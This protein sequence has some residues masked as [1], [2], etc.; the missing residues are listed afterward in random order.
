M[1]QRDRFARTVTSLL[2]AQLDD[3]RW[4]AASALL[5]DACDIWGNHL[6]V[7]HPVSGGDPEMVFGRLYKRGEPDEELERRYTDDYLAIDERMPRFFA[8]SDGALNHVKVMF[9][10]EELATSPTYNEFLVPSGGENAVT[11]RMAGPGGLHI[12]MSLVRGG[13][14]PSSWT[15]DQVQMIQRLLPHIRHFVR[16]RQAMVNAGMSAVHTAADAFG[17]KEIG[18]VFL[19]ARGRIVGLNDYARARL[20]AG[21]GLMDRRGYL[22][23]SHASD[24]PRLAKLLASTLRRPVSETAGGTVPVRRRGRPPLTLH[25][26]PLAAH[27]DDIFAATGAFAG[28][29]LI[30]DPLDKPRVNPIR[31]ADALDLTPA[32]AR[33]AAALASG[34]NVRSIAAMSHRSEAVVRWHLK[35]IMARL[36]LHGQT[37]LVRLVLT[38][39]GIYEG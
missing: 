11:V 29:A 22:T 23:T 30:V 14:D 1:D 38:T 16:V 15:A 12:L 18:V 13:G 32:Q 10:P 20:R 33:I 17:A 34:D 39:P 8:M 5:D 7:I 28:M 25:I 2:E 6:A 27:S 9:T 36:R 31:L 35:Q 26:S 21:D 4:P 24:G 3:S 37:D 19:D